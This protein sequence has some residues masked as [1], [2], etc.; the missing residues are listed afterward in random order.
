M[1]VIAVGDR[2]KIE[3]QIAALKLGPIGHRTLEGE[4]V[5]GNQTVKMPLP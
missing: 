3:R 5:R 1:K 4:P 2:A